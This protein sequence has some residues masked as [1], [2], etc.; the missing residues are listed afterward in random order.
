MTAYLSYR[1]ER[2]GMRSLQHVWIVDPTRV[3]FVDDIAAELAALYPGVEVA[4]STPSGRPPDLALIPFMQEECSRRA[5]RQI[6]RT[7]TRSRPTFLGLYEIGKRHLVVI[8]RNRLPSLLLRLMAEEWL[9]LAARVPT[10]LM[11]RARRLFTGNGV[12]Q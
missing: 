2:A 10:G 5:M 1:L 11:R 4:R 7:A 3:W 9:R 12:Q 8:P 6:L